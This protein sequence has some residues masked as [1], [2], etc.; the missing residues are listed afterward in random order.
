MLTISVMDN[1]QG[2]N[3]EEKE[4]LHQK[5]LS[6][7]KTG[8]SI[9]LGNLYRRIAKLYPDGE[10]KVHSKEGCGTIVQLKIPQKEGRNHEV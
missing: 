3:M 6:S 4:A 1:G 5:I 8:R 7:E 10:L 2:M 9:G